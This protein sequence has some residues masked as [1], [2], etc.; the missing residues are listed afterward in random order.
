[1]LSVRCA[2][3]FVGS[4]DHGNDFSNTLRNLIIAYESYKV[5]IIMKI[6]GMKFFGESNAK[7]WQN[8]CAFGRIDSNLYVWYNF[9]VENG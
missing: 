1:M 4:A 8:K 9:S 6:A 3:Q 5:T 7:N 2:S